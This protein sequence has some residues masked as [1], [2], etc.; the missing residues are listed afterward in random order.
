MHSHQR[1]LYLIPPFPHILKIRD[2]SCSKKSK[3]GT[4][5]CGINGKNV[6]SK[7]SVINLKKCNLNTQ[8]SLWFNLNATLI[9][10][11]GTF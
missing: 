2:S 1:N 7:K 5:D 9:K 6:H 3:Y 11:R 8:D 10:F 4:E